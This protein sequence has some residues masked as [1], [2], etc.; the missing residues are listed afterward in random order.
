MEVLEGTVQPALHMLNLI[1]QAACIQ[2]G[3]QHSEKIIQRQFPDIL[4]SPNLYQSGGK[5]QK[6][7][8]LERLANNN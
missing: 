6:A 4:F 5:I 7:H 2:R 8:V 3:N 1:I